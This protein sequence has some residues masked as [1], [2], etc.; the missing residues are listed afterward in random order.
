MPASHAACQPAALLP[1]DPASSTKMTYGLPRIFTGI[2]CC[3]VAP[4][5]QN[6]V[7]MSF[8]CAFARR[9]WMS[10]RS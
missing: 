8:G 6:S 4:S 5:F 10:E 2:V 1:P 3:A 9:A 7:L